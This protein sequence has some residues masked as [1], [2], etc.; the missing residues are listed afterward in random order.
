MQSILLVEPEFPI[1]AKSR[2]HKNFLPIGL[3][4]IAS[5]LRSKNI[6]VK[7]FRGIPKTLNEYAEILEFNPKEVWITS[8]FTYWS[9]YVKE[10]VQ[11]YKRLLP[12]SKTVVGGIFASL[13]SREK[14]IEVTGCD[15]VYQGVMYE[16]EE[17]PPAYDLI[18]GCNPHPLDY[19]I[20]HTSRGCMR[21]CGFCGTWKIEPYFI[22][23][24]SIKNEIFQK[25]IV[26]YDNN[27]LMNPH[28]EKILQELI[29]LKK[30]GKIVWCESQ[31][32]FD[33]RILLEKPYLAKLIKKAGFIYPRV[34]WDSKYEDYPSIKKQIDILVD[35]G[36]Q[37]KSIFIFMLYNWDIPFEEMELKRLKCWDWKIQISDCRYRPLNQLYDNFSHKIKNQSSEDYYIH[38]LWSDSLI[39]QFRRNIREQNICIRHNL[40]FYSRR[41]EQKKVGKEVFNEIKNLKSKLELIEFLEGHGIDYWFPDQIRYPEDYK[42]K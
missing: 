23:K 17:Y 21:K 38:P 11:F 27:F 35:A 16:A 24:K 18:S 12:G 41:L 20:I 26:F 29:E 6:N 42:N 22:A 32:G 8:L 5:Y 19:Q 15:D 36:Y 28:V 37:T 4:K 9:K 40:L 14:V 33:G 31:S 1:P 39:K 7:L 30:Q 3:L 2:N 10:A 34:A 13:L 25:K